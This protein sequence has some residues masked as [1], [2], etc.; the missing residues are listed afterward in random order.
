MSTMADAWEERVYLDWAATAPLCEEAASAMAPYQAG[1]RANIA[2]N[3]NANSLHSEGRTAFAAMEGA[4][5]ALARCI[6]ARPDELIFT[7]GATESD[8]AAVIGLTE[9]ARTRREQHGAGSFTPHIITTSI[10]HDAVVNPAKLLGAHG[11]DVTLLAP[12]AQG[13]ISVDSLREALTPNTVLVS[14]MTANNEIGTIQDIAALA[15]IAHDAGALFHTD[16]VQAF[17][18]IPV[19]CKALGVDALSISAHKICGPKGMGALYVRHGV[20]MAPYLLGGGQESGRR[21]G[22]QNV[23]GM[24]GFA[25]AA[26][27]LCGDAEAFEAE[28]TRQRTLRD[29]LYRELASHPGVHASVACAAGSRDFLPNIV[30]VCVDGIESETLILQLDLLG[31][32]IAGGS[33]CSSSSLDPSRVLAAIGVPR[34]RALGSMRVSIGRYTDE[35][36]VERFCSAFAR[37]LSNRE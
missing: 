32:A 3:A 30:N 24:V 11:V 20:K 18:K 6:N 5:T 35:H 25:A 17:G 28:T 37:V 22:T 1:G 7:G 16:A 4:R 10:E 14:V 29:T 23:A 21:S 26:E 19:D 33:A 15:A 13:I 31:F 2:V 27:A 9:A 36:D 12:D 8:N 34:D